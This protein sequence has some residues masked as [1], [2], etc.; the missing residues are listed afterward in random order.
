M[1]CYYAII[2][3]NKASVESKIITFVAKFNAQSFITLSSV[4][5]VKLRDSERILPPPGNDEVGLAVSRSQSS[6][7]LQC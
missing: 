6:C 3:V 1:Q 2:R 7:D 4:L 5:G